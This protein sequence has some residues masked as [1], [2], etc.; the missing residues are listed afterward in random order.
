MGCQSSII[1]LAP[2]HLP[3]Q[4]PAVASLAHD[5]VSVR[6]GIGGRM[7]PWGVL[8]SEREICDAIAYART[9]CER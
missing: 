3:H 7:P 9:F 6:D 1:S 4:L 2:D 8:L 5:L